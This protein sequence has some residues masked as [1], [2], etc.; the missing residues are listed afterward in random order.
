LKGLFLTQ[1]VRYIESM[2]T[3]NHPSGLKKELYVYCTLLSLPI[4]FPMHSIEENNDSVL[5]LFSAYGMDNTLP[6]GLQSVTPSSLMLLGFTCMS[7]GCVLFFIMIRE[8]P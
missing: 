7:S 6:S 1:L 5:K 3:W 4:L 2:W 8:N